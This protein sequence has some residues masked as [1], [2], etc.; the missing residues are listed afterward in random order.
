M[1]KFLLSFLGGVVGALVV[2]SVFT[3]TSFNPT[4][5]QTI[6]TN[7][8]SSNATEVYNN[9]INGVVTVLN[10]QSQQT[11]QQFLQGESASL[12]NTGIGSGFIYKKEGGYYYALTNNHVISD[13]ESIKILTSNESINDKLSDA[14]LVG[15]DKIYDVAIIKFKSKDNLSVLSLGDS[16]KLETGQNV[17]AIGSPYGTDFTGSISSGILSAPIRKFEKNLHSYQ[18]IQTDAPINPGNSGGPLLDETGKV[19]G[20]NS[21]KIADTE[22]DNMGFAIPI[23]MVIDIANSLED[24]KIPSDEDTILNDYEIRRKDDDSDSSSSDNSD[25][26]VTANQLLNDLLKQFL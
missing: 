22:A 7:S 16:D 3:I 15:T 25:D 14:T 9:S 24:G 20:M 10:Y 23:N 19:I 8:N 4:Q 5:T 12:V 17:Y 26:K 6:V 1:K 13:S 2:I 18:Y 21:M 11:L